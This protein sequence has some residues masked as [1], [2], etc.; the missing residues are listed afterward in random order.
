MVWIRGAVV[1]GE[2]ARHTGRAVQGVIVVLMAV[3]AL[4]RRHSVRSGQSEAGAGVVELAITP[5]DRVVTRCAS[6][7]KIG[8]D[9]VHR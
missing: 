8:G 4:S 3:R 6:R 1:I 2:M 5:L 7:R 9:M